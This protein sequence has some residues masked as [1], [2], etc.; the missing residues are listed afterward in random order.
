M[1]DIKLIRENPEKIKQAVLDK[2]RSVDV[3]KIVELDKK[4]RELT[5][6][7]DELRHK[8]K[9]FGK[10]D[11]EKAQANKQ[12]LKKLE[13]DA[14]VGE[15]E[16]I[17]LLY[18]VPNP[19]A[20]FVPKGGEENNK[21]IKTIGKIPAFDFKPKDH[22]EL[23]EALNIIDVKRATKVSG[24]R[25]VALKNDLALLQFSLYRHIIDKLI[26]KGFEFIIPPT[27]INSEAMRGMG[28]VE[29]GGDKETYYLD[30]D[31][32]YLIG[33]SEHVIG[34]MRKDETFSEPELPHR[35]CGFSPCYRREAGSYGKDT[36]GMFRLHQFYKV[37]MFSYVTPEQSD[38]EL[39][40]LLTIEE[41]IVNEMK[42]PYQ[43]VLIASGDLGDPASAKYDIEAWFPGQNKYREI[44]STSNTTDFQARRLNIRY[45][46]KQG[47]T[48]LVHTLNGT[49]AADRMLIAI[50]ENYQQ[51]DGSIKIP[52]V[53][54]PYFGKKE[55]R[56]EDKNAD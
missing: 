8:Q 42:L 36:R 4:N 28:Y 32:M 19:S 45:K 55:I 43:V 18:L 16:L 51:K 6:K 47:K 44:T 9:Q 56:L 11:L 5:T 33:T 35:V 39:E 48:G 17:D 2:A 23:G 25:F 10:E 24:S 12:E 41:E 54:V 7:I 26:G 15:K 52:E 50:L 30:K 21:I 38:K 29:H 22:L 1:I 49:G 27:L 40:N 3:D 34:A 53:L 31:D 37:E 13:S 20:D 14:K 46:S